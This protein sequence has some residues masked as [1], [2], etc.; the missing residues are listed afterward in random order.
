MS[1]FDHN[2]VGI[3]EGDFNPIH[4]GQ[5]EAA[6]AFM[7]QMKLDYIFIVPRHIPDG[8]EAQRL[9][10]CELAFDG[11]DGVLISDEEIKGQGNITL[12]DTVRAR[13]N[14][15]TRVF[16]LLGSDEVLNFDKK[17]DFDK[18]LRLCYP[19]YARRENDAI[20]EKRIVET[21]GRYY[22]E[23][24]VMFRRILVE[25]QEISSTDL[26][27]AIARGEDASHLVPTSVWQFIK[28]NELYTD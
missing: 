7:E 6:K 12:C 28:E 22:K 16:V 9:K 14:D 21:L 10:M 5:V 20:I 2:R 24:G 19:V 11:V 18:M 3:F 4:N 13:A 15:N 27:R 8:N 1:S 26:R 25:T 23:Y 17:P